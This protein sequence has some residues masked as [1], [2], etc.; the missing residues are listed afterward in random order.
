MEMPETAYWE[1]E[2][3]QVIFID[4]EKVF[5]Y[6]YYVT[7]YRNDTAKAEVRRCNRWQKVK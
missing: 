6:N 2:G 3:S 1:K 4:R 7:V 5:Y